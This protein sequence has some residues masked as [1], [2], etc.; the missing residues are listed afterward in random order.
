MVVKG[1]KKAIFAHFVTTE[2]YTNGDTQNQHGTPQLR[3][4]RDFN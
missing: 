4:H 1:S 3:G 2:N